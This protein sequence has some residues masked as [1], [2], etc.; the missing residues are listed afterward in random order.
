MSESTAHNRPILS[1]AVSPK[2]DDDRENLQQ[3]LN[4]L[5]QKDPT[6]SIKTEPIDGKTIIC[7]MGELHLEAICDRLVHENKIQIEISK[8][9]VICLET[10]RKKSEAEGKYIRAISSHSTYG[11]VKLRLEP[12]EE[13]SGYQFADESS[14]DAIP[15]KFVGSVDLGFQEAMKGGILAGHEMTDLRA[16][17]YDG[18]YYVGDSNEMAFK[19]AASIAF[20]EAARKADP[21]VLEPVMSIEVI[22]PQDFAGAIIG[23]LA[24]RR[25]R[26]GA[27]EHRADSVVIT[28]IAPLDEMIGYG[29]HIRS[30]THGRA[31]YSMNFVHYQAAPE[32]GESGPDGAGVTANRPTIPKSGRG[33]AAANADPE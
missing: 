22:T 31:N 8:P 17:L 4:D 13:G 20:K 26:I 28:A 3:A 32:F 9:K 27:M 19:I 33:F 7:G 23:D 24:S 5:T 25:A 6:V 21:V 14:E 11:H 16:T 30:V 29:T 18:S 1:V 15:R 2:T 12:R 10:I